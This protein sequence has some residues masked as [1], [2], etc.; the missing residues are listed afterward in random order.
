[1]DNYIIFLFFIQ[2]LLFLSIVFEFLREK[3]WG[4]QYL[5]LNTA[6]KGIAEDLAFHSVTKLRERE[7]AGVKM[8]N[9]RMEREKEMN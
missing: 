3:N 8:D 6:K 9:S 1:M 7:S 5:T 4:S 2:T